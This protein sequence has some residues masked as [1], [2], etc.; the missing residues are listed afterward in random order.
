MDLRLSIGQNNANLHRPMQWF[1]FS[2]GFNIRRQIPGS[3]LSRCYIRYLW[4]HHRHTPTRAT[5][6]LL[7]R[8]YSRLEETRV[9]ILTSLVHTSSKY[10]RF[11][12]VQWDK[13]GNLVQCSVV[14]RRRVRWYHARS[15]T[16]QCCY[17]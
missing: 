17:L 12:G 9:Y 1:N 8:S 5:I 7:K 14:C 16:Q 15:K 10:C 11:W 2:S 3:F 13:D 4:S 6:T